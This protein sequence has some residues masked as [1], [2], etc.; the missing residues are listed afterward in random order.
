MDKVRPLIYNV[1]FVGKLT[2]SSVPPQYREAK[3]WKGINKEGAFDEYYEDLFRQLLPAIRRRYSIATH[4]FKFCLK[5]GIKGAEVNYNR[6]PK[7]YQR[8]IT[9]KKEKVRRN[10]KK[11]ENEF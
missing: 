7:E 9:G 10:E 11:E 4:T 5:H 2:K 3:P 1:C 8:T 6:L